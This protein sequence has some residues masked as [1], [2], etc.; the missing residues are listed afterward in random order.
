MYNTLKG[1]RMASLGSVLKTWKDGIAETLYCTFFFT[2]TIWTFRFNLIADMY[3]RKVMFKIV[4]L[5][6]YSG[7]PICM[8]CVWK[9]VL[10]SSAQHKYY[11]PSFSFWKSYSTFVFII[12]L[13]EFRIYLLH[14]KKKSTSQKKCA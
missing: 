9:P 10:W 2:Y 12:C 6:K 8:C 3:Y 1:N 13:S 5:E 11:C 4:W 7:Y 14:H